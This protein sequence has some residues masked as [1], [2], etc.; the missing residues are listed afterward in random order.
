MTATTTAT[1]LQVIQ[2]VYDNF[3]HGDIS[4][5]V[6]L[7]AEGAPW[8]Q[9]PSLPWGGHYVGPL[10]ALEF[11]QKLNAH[12]EPVSF[13]DHENIE[14]GDEIFTFGVYT[15]KSRKTGR[16]GAANLMFRWRVADGKIVSWNSYIDSAALLAA[17]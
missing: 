17:L 2:S 5:I 3:R 11:F 10:G 12:M 13:E 7:V 4:A 8:S 15:G 14:V 1:P 6:A 9:S 16:T